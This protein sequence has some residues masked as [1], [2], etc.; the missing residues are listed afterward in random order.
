M[1]ILE[2]NINYQNAHKRFKQHKN[3]TPKQK[4]KRTTTE[5]NAGRIHIINVL[6]TFEILA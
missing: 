4:T 6:E 1:T 3:S 5:A 2:L